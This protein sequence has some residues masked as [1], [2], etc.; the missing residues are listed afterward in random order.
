MGQVDAVGVNM[1]VVIQH[2]VILGAG[3]PPGQLDGVGI[4]GIAVHHTLV[5]L[6][7]AGVGDA[8]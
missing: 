4:T 6:D 2:I 3:A 1:G 8:H 5:R 7:G